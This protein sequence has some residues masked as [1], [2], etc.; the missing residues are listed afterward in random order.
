MPFYRRARAPSRISDLAIIS[1]FSRCGLKMSPTAKL[2]CCL[3]F[4]TFL[5]SD[6]RVAPSSPLHFPFHQPRKLNQLSHRCVCAVQQPV[7]ECAHAQTKAS[8]CFGMWAVPPTCAVTRLSAVR[9]ACAV[10]Q[11]SAVR[12]ACAV[13]RLSLARPACAVTRLSVARP[14]CAVIRLSSY[15]TQIPT[16]PWYGLP[17]QLLSFPRY[18]W[19]AQLSGYPVIRSTACLGSHPVIRST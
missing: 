14:S 9:L 15:P 17:A 12:L 4:V 1:F 13:T 18:D 16:Y 2:F 7:V 8:V 11:L 5:D 10:I 6:C 19:P 3:K